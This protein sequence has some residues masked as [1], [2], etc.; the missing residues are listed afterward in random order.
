MSPQLHQ[1]AWMDE[2]IEAF[3]RELSR[4][5]AREM[6]PHLDGWRRQGF[7]PREVWRGFGAMGYLLPEMSEEFGGGGVSLAYQLVAQDELA[8][9]EMPAT[10]SVHT[11]AAHYI[12]DFGTEAQKRR[13]LP[14]LVSGEFLAGHRHDRTGLRLR[15]QGDLHPRPASG[16]SLCDRRRQDLHHG[17]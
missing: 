1:H 12:H 15:S 2:S 10:P 5:I 7:I 11:I 16:G 4:Y 8:R 13:W 9:A 14:G 6:S 17:R 3:R